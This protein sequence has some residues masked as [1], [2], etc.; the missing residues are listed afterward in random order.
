MRVG[1]LAGATTVLATTDALHEDLNDL[2]TKLGLVPRREV[3]SGLLS[4]GVADKY[5][6]RVDLVWSLALSSVQRESIGWLLQR[7]VTEVTELPMVAVEVEAT[8]PSTK[9]VEADIANLCAFGAPLG[10]V[11][12]SEKGEQG[13]YRRAA[14]TIRTLRRSFGDIRVL[15]V[16]A[17]WVAPLRARTWTSGTQVAP[18][19]LR[20][21]PAGGETR[22]WTATARREFKE[23]GERAGFVVAEPYVPTILATA[24]EH[25]KATRA[26]RHM[27]D[28]RKKSFKEI[29]RAADYFSA[30]KLDMAWLLPLPIA[31][32]EFVGELSMCDPCLTENGMLFA[33]AWG[34]LPLAAIEFETYAGKHAGGGLLNLA[35]YGVFGVAVG[36]SKAVT[37]DL[38]SRLAT[39]RPTLG[40]RNVFVRAA[41]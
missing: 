13:Q 38:E 15:P 29:L 8:A 4:T 22:D 26:L 21:A 27:T 33:N 31:L 12:V 20:L 36:S 40:L 17:D 1:C 24:F 10:L 18:Q 39:Y 30:S 19:N 16:E 9:T 37:R 23:R 41:P 32:S 14:R 25:V 28:P 34:Y 2:A 3:S 6:P 35:A 11:V 5:R 7:P